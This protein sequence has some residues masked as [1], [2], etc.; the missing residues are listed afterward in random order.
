M[1][2]NNRFIYL[3]IPKTGGVSFRQILIDAFPANQ[4]KHVAPGP[5][6]AEESSESLAKYNVVHGHFNLG[7]IGHIKDFKRVV[8]L[9]DPVT[10]CISAY[11][12]WRSLDPSDPRWDENGRLM[13]AAS[14]D[15]TID[16]MLT[17][18]DYRVRSV[19]SNKQ[20]RLLSGELDSCSSL[21]AMHLIKA[22]GALQEFDFIGLNEEL[23]LSKA[24]FCF[25]FGL[26]CS[27]I[28]QRLN[29]SRYKTTVSDE[30]LDRLRIANH[31]DIKLIRFVQ[32]RGLFSLNGI[33][34]P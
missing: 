28:E 17:H 14:H 10:R 18:A 24:L 20:V 4:I 6:I 15:C 26:Y 25:K 34:I 2:K 33:V 9:R 22:V 32:S 27:G 31:L 1:S 5:K 21:S 11:N 3:H 29:K 30:T 13:I 7:D 19:F 16:Q 12:F 8:T 23:A